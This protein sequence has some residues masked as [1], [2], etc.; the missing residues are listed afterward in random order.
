ME[1]II[2]NALMVTPLMPRFWWGL[3]LSLTIA[4]I[5]TVPV[6]RW[7]ISRNPHSHMHH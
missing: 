3:A 4:F 7:M 6:N 1:L 5:L 2:P